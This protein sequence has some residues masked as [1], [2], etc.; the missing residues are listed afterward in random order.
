MRGDELLYSGL[1]SR[2][3]DDPITT[4]T[5]TTP[6][7]GDALALIR[8]QVAQLQND[9]H[10]LAQVVSTSDDSSLSPGSPRR[11][12]RSCC[13]WWHLSVILARCG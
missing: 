10:R 6:R 4:T 8:S 9:N 2:V 13:R 12:L 5:T 1:P 7:R 3:Y 11:R